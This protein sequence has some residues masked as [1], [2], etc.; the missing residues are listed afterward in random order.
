L[1]E[2]IWGQ[3]WEQELVQKTIKTWSDVDAKNFPSRSLVEGKGM[4][5]PSSDLLG[6][7]EPVSTR[8]EAAGLGGFQAWGTDNHGIGPETI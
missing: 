3:F 1:L 4:V 7:A 6:F 5:C 2:Q 8:L